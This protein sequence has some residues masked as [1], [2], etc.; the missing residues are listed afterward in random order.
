MDTE[1]RKIQRGCQEARTIN[2]TKID[3]DI[4]QPDVSLNVN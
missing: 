3:L 4:V 2:K 1:I